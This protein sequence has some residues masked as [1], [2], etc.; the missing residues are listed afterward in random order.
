[1]S[2]NEVPVF[3]SKIVDMINARHRLMEDRTPGLLEAA[4][5]K[6]DTVEFQAGGP[7][8]RAADSGQT[9]PLEKDK[10]IVKAMGDAAEAMARS[11]PGGTTA[12][13]KT[14]SSPRTLGGNTLP[15]APARPARPSVAATTATRS[16]ASQV[17]R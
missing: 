16:S 13:R 17:Q 6:L 3:L 12:W 15:T 9:C 14:A 2:H 11:T 7:P 5:V 4:N 10:D 8:P 1:M